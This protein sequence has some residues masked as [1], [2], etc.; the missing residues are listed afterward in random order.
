[1][2]VFKT[3]R[4]PQSQ[5]DFFQAMASEMLKAIDRKLWTIRIVIH[6][7]TK[8]NRQSNQDSAL[9]TKCRRL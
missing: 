5:K 7:L 3:H 2:K 4:D 1:M 8:A 9:K 6:R